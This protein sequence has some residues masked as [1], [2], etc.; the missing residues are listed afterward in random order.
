[1]YYQLYKHMHLFLIWIAGLGSRFIWVNLV[2]LHG[3]EKRKV[4]IHM[5]KMKCDPCGYPVCKNCT[6]FTKL[7]NHKFVKS[8]SQDW[9]CYNCVQVIFPFNH[10]TNDDVFDG[11]SIEL[12]YDCD[13]LD[14]Q[15]LQSE[16]VDPFNFDDKKGYIPHSD[17]NPNSCYYNEHSYTRQMNSNCYHEDF[18]NHF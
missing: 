15:Y 9:T 6:L 18:F 1:M 8:G 3:G 11:C 16:I 13:L 4:L 2:A 7:G 5:Y 10:F 17:I 14:L 12:Y